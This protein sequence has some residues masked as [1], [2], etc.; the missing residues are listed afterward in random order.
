MPPELSA[1]FIGTPP[2]FADQ[3]T[4]LDIGGLDQDQSCAGS[5]EAYS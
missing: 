5:G 4:G 1:P 3:M 2:S